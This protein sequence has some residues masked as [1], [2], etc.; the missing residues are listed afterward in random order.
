M[1]I[2]RAT[3]KV[4]RKAAAAL[5]S[6][7]IAATASAMSDEELRA[8]TD[9]IAAQYSTAIAHCQSLQGNDK[10]ICIEDAKGSQRVAQ[11]ERDAKVLGDAGH[12]YQVRVARAEADYRVANERCNEMRGDAVGICKKDAEAAYRKAQ[13]DA[14]VKRVEAPPA[15][16][17]D[18]PLT[19][20]APARSDLPLANPPR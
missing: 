5:A 6:L 9:R 17:T 18:R 1:L 2:K 8:E 15:M 11:A 13:Q 14:Q 3:P 10:H 7:C 16:S 12:S 19:P 4:S 20:L